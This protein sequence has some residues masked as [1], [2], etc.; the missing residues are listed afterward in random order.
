MTV[1]NVLVRLGERRARVDGGSVQKQ[2]E[3]VQVEAAI[4]KE[5]DSR[6]FLR[7]YR[8]ASDDVVWAQRGVVA[9][10][11]NGEAGSV[12]RRR[13]QDAGFK[14]LDLL[15]LGGDRVLVRSPEGTDVLT[16][17][18]QARDFFNL[19]FSHW[20]RWEKTAIPFQRG[21][22][23]RIYGIP[24]H[25]WNVNF[26]KLCV[27]DCGRFLRPDSY[28]VARDRLDYARVLIST[29]A[30]AVVKKV[31][32]LLVDGS[33]VEIQIIEEWG[34]DLGDDACLMED[35]VE[36]KASLDADDESRGDPEASNQVD[37]LVDHIAKEV[38]DATCIDSQQQGDAAQSGRTHRMPQ[39]TRAG[40]RDQGFANT[41]LEPV[42]ISSPS[43]GGSIECVAETVLT[44]QKQDRPAEVQVT[45]NQRKR[46][47]SCPPARRSILSG[48]WSLGWLRDHNLGDAGVIFSTRKHTKQGVVLLELSIR[49][50]LESQL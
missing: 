6:I 16:V 2:G 49:G 9:T 4:D 20:E 14:D 18:D 38:E 7:S 26:F 1:G 48:P 17:F 32:Q 46:T 15:H 39:V 5:Q 42:E 50:R 24:L 29:T 34:F 35:D 13:L 21:A 47:M 30:L 31:E 36:S 10:V 19:C 41:V 23:V 43:S 37:M 12:V 44:T 45:S 3:V 22:W 8:A 27:M 25:A 11:A 40:C 33:L 28:T